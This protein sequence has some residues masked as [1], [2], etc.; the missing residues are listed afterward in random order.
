MDPI[1]TNGFQVQA[2]PGLQYLP[3]SQMVGN[4]SGI[5][6]AASQ[7]AA[8]DSQLSQIQNEAQ[9]APIRQALQ[10]IQLQ[11][12]QNKLSQFPQ[13]QALAL[14][15]LQNIQKTG[16][17]PLKDLEGITL[18]GG[19]QTEYPSA[20]DENGDRTGPS[21]FVTNPLVKIQEETK[22]GPGGVASQGQE[23]TMLKTADQIDAERAH[24]A[25]TIRASD[26]LAAYHER[27]KTF[28]PSTM[29]G[30]LDTRDAALQ[31]AKDARNSGDEASAVAHEK[32]A[33]QMDAII[34]GS[35]KQGTTNTPANA[36]GRKIAEMAAIAGIAQETAAEAAKT[37]DGANLVAKTYAM[38]TGMARGVIIDPE[39]QLTPAEIQAG[40]DAWATVQARRAKAAGTGSGV[41]PMFTVPGLGG[42]PAAPAAA[43]SIPQ[44]AVD[45]LKQN[46]SLAD[47]FDAMYGAGAADSVLTPS[48]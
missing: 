28:R 38:K 40:K 19:D 12:A 48:G 1:T 41:A 5:L 24:A 16:A 4:L 27:P 30:L 47:D 11:D 10:R 18:Q 15:Q 25:A 35:A 44:A 34:N 32:T 29:Q 13:Q 3:A 46:P 43:S 7:G 2:R 22:Y 39:M 45:H 8:F 14:A 20:L 37:P 36:G 33:A 6:P 42:A 21:S 23:S 31:D 17:A 9:A 26:A